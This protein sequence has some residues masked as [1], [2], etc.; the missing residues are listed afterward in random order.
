MPAALIMRSKGKI[1]ESMTL[2]QAATCLNPQNP[3]NLKQL[4]RCFFLLGK[5]KSALDVYD[6]VHKVVDTKHFIGHTHTGYDMPTT[7]SRKFKPR[8]CLLDSPLACG[9]DDSALPSLLYAKT[10]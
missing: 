7:I 2:Y 6:E 5:H 9:C 4:G 1:H 10:K 8:N 3:A